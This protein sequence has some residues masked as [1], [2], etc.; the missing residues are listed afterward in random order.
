MKKL[1]FLFFIFSL[2]F[3]FAPDY[4]FAASC[5][6]GGTCVN[7]SR[8]VCNPNTNQCVAKCKNDQDCDPGSYCTSGNYCQQSSCDPTNP[9]SCPDGSFCDENTKL[10]VVSLSNPSQPGQVN[11]PSPFG[12]TFNIALNNIVARVVAIFFFLIGLILLGMIGYAGF[13]FM[14]GGSNEDN[15]KKAQKIFLSAVI[16]IAVIGLTGLIVTAIHLIFGI[17]LGL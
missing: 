17:N 14:T 3:I 1:K 13:L 12:T 2:L 8:Y 9:A 5:G 7:P 4:T 11:I 6:T 16:G 15:V 10:C